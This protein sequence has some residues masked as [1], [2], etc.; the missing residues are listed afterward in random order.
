MSENE[1]LM[2]ISVFRKLLSESYFRILTC[3]YVLLDILLIIKTLSATYFQV[4][5]AAAKCMEAVIGAR[6][7]RVQQL[8]TTTGPQLI[9]RFKE[10]EDNVKAD[11]FQV[12]K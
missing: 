6:R 12:R 8:L 2:L 9:N 5:R 10:R 3:T 7:D 4:R 11:I 1:F